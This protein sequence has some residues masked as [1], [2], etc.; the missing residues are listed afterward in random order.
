MVDLGFL[1]ICF[2]VIT[3]TMAQPRETKL[4]IPKGGPDMNLPESRTLTVLLGESEKIFYYAGSWDNGLSKNKILTT[5]Y[6]TYEGIGNVIREKQK[7]LRARATGDTPENELILIIKASEK[8]SYGN[9]VDMLDEVLINGLKHYVI[10]DLSE[11]E[12]E[13]IKN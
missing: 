3:T 11:A 6:S 1:L 4:I 9:L 7:Q 8:S 12:K 2:F 5:N 10:A 13:Y